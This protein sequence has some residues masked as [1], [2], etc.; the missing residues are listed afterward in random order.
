MATINAIDS[1]IPI[2]VGQGGTGAATL[3]ANGVLVGAT[4]SAISGITAGSTGQLLVGS[5]SANPAFA[6]SATGDFTFTSSTASQTRILTISNTDNTGSATSSAKEQITVGGANVGDPSKIYT[7]TGAQSWAKGLD[8]SSSDS[9]K[10][11]AGTALGTTDKFIMTTAGHRTLPATCAF[12]VK[13]ALQSNVTGNG[14]VYT[15]TFTTT[16]FDQASNF[17][18]PNFTAPVSGNYY[19]SV[20][21]SPGGFLAG[22]TS[23]IVNLVTTTNTYPIYEWNPS[24]TGLLQKRGVVLAF[25]NATDTAHVT[26]QV[27]GSTKVIN[28]GATNNSTFM[29]FLVS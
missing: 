17:S 3:T 14:T 4:T 21:L 12:N 2:V 1:N 9:Y 7:I 20:N 23:S 13:A 27:S 25:M 5:S 15:V 24:V 10:I 29:G 16:I 11:S 8:N 6:S 28:I 22:H 26:I 18:S 19:F